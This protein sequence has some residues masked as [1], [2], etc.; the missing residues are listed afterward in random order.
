MSPWWNCEPCK[1]RFYHDK[2]LQEIVFKIQKEDFEYELNLR[3]T[4]N[5]T[6]IF[7]TKNPET[8]NSKLTWFF[9]KK[10][11]DIPYLIQNVTPQ[12]AEQKLATILTFS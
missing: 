2:D 8:N 3:L 11:L 7:R 12:N 5:R 1:A 10:I 4:G 9:A 6:I